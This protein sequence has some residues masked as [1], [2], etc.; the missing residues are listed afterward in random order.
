MIQPKPPKVNLE[1]LMLYTGEVLRFECKMMQLGCRC[2]AF[3]RAECGPKRPKEGL[4]PRS[5]AMCIRNGEPEDE[6]RTLVIA[7]Y[8]ADDETAVFEAPWRPF[9]ALG[10]RGARAE[11]R[12]HGRQ[13]LREAADQEPG[14]GGVL[15]ARGSSL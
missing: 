13:V 7:F 1:K 8:P 6:L 9:E 12:P 10:C 14:H 4:G 3:D 11:Q 15:Q 5:A 2:P